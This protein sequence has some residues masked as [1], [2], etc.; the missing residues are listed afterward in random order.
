MA[1]VIF[2]MAKI[3]SWGG[4]GGAAGHNLRQR[5]TPNAG[6][7]GVIEIVSCKGSAAKAVRKKIGTQTIRKNAVLA[8]EAVISASPE[9]FRPNAP[10]RC[11]YYDPARLE[12]WRKKVEPWILAEFPHAVSVVLHLD[13]AT[14]HYQVID[15][16]LDENGKLNCRGKYGG[17]TV[18]REWQ[19]R[20]AR[21]VAPLGIERGLRGSVA[22]HEKIQRFYGAVNTPLPNIPKVTT[23]S[24]RSMPRLGLFDKFDAGKKAKAEAAQRQQAK[25]QQEITARYR[26]L[27]EA[28]QRLAARAAGFDLAVQQKEEALVMARIAQRERDQMSRKFQLMEEVKRK[29]YDTQQALKKTQ[30]ALSEARKDVEVVTG[31]LEIAQREVARLQP[32]KESSLRTPKKGG[33]FSD[34]KPVGG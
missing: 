2:R 9:Y 6:P 1:Q 18:L 34:F 16:P 31:D 11:G 24:P 12:A 17:K 33:T 32:P 5:T 15:V 4:I 28:Y 10:A 8:V 21:A 3:K 19:E 27:E 26:A 20:A 29:L 25:R 14:P 23:P 7:G 30:E 13:E 22:T